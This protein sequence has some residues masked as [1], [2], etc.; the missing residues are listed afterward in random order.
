LRFEGR[1]V[2]ELKFLQNL[3]I[4]YSEVI[5]KRLWTRLKVWWFIRQCNKDMD[6]LIKGYSKQ[7]RE[8]LK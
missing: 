8:T 5:M 7:L 2:R 1:L 4:S 6:R 3:P